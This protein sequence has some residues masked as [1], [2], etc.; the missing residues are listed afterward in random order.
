MQHSFHSMH[1]ASEP[2]RAL[3]GH[4]RRLPFVFGLGL[5]GGGGGVLSYPLLFAPPGDLVS[6]GAGALSVFLGAGLVYTAYGEAC[7]QC[8]AKMEDTYATL[9]L[10]LVEQV[11]SAVLAAK[12]GDLD[13]IVLL[14]G[15][16][17]APPHAR[18]T[19]SLELTYCPTCRQVGKLSS[20]QRRCLS[21]GTTVR[22]ETSRPVV[23][24]GFAL[25]QALDVIVARNM[26]LTR[27]QYGNGQ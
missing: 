2:I 11:R 3:K 22:R 17:L 18:L 9:P 8:R 6:L 16:P 26:A 1:G 19:A 12:M 15:V 13:W 7:S 23:L 10:E 25:S 5:L 20:A 14:T 21:D 24:S 27:A 4:F